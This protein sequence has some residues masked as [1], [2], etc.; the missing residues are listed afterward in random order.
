LSYLRQPVNSNNAYSSL[1]IHLKHFEEEEEVEPISSSGDGGTKS[2]SPSSP[3]SMHRT[4]SAESNSA[5]SPLVF[6]SR[7][8]GA[9]QWINTG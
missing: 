2:A 1:V 5:P 9:K 8:S 7:L 4:V 6:L 3:S